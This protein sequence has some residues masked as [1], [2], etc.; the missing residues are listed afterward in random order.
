[1]SRGPVSG[2]VVI[3]LVAA[4]L[5]GCGGDERSSGRAADGATATGTVA[6][7]STTENIEVVRARRLRKA[8]ASIAKRVD[9]PVVLPTNLPAGASL[10]SDPDIQNAS[11]QIVLDIGLPHFLLIDY[12]VSDLTTCRGFRRVTVGDAPGLM[13]T[14]KVRPDGA[15]EDLPYYTVV[16]PATPELPEGLYAV[17]GTFTAAKILAF[18]RAMKGTTSFAPRDS[19]AHCFES[20]K[21]AV[22]YVSKHVDVTVVAPTN[23]PNGT[24][25][26][27][28]HG[29]GQLTLLLPDRRGLTIQ[30]GEAGFDG[31]GPLHPREVRVGDNP[32]VIEVSKVHK[33]GKRKSSPYTTLVWPATLNDLEGRYG[34]SG[35]FS[36]KEML[37]F[38]ESMDKARA[39][40]PRGPKTNC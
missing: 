2:W 4:V 23:L 36:E 34:L 13:S 11:G 9:V 20:I 10:S 5:V 26:E 3:A 40:K 28:V 6:P 15:S 1:M 14:S 29:H 27:S 7:A 19:E 17:S 16:W 31:C 33:S 12:G 39:A 24:T 30:Y 18:A 38:A 22:D 35:E 21:A 25:V 8:L 37:A 32:A